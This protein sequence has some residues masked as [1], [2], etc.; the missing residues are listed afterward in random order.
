MTEWEWYDDPIVF[1]IFLK[2]LLLA[3][4]EDK[5]WHGIKVPKG[6]FISSYENLSSKKANVSIQNVRTAIKKLKSTGELTIKSTNKFTI[7]QVQNWE[8]YQIT[9]KQINRQTNKQLTNNQQTTNKQLTTTK[10][11]KNIRIKENNY[12]VELEKVLIL[13]NDTYQTKR[14][15]FK[16]IEANYAYWREIYSFE[17]I[18]EAIS[19]STRTWLSG[20][21]IET[22]FRQKNPNGEHVDYIA[23]CLESKEP[24]P[25]TIKLGETKL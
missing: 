17:E 4:H 9:N 23:V 12:F 2:C 13:W 24:L 1:W 16:T 10:E 6:S 20:K 5:K 22:F 11:Y 8:K 19:K 3:N 15:S 25:D 14:T 7:F 18:S 21:P